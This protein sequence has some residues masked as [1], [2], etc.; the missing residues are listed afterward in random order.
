MHSVHVRFKSSTSLCHAEVPGHRGGPLTE[1]E[2][3]DQVLLAVHRGHA[4]PSGTGERFADD[5]LSVCV[6]ARILWYPLRCVCVIFFFFCAQ[7]HEEFKQN[8]EN[9]G[10]RSLIQKFTEQKGTGKERPGSAHLF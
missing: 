4:R 10:I 9:I 8:V 5:C 7:V 3:A 2:A 1:D 6:F